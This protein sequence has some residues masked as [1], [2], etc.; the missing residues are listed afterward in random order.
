MLGLLSAAHSLL[1]AAAV[2][3][4]ASAWIFQQFNLYLFKYL[5]MGLC[6]APSVFLCTEYEDTQSLACHFHFLTK[7]HKGKKT[8]F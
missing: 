8:C 3:N 7:I 6:C 1:V 2:K 4:S 5:S